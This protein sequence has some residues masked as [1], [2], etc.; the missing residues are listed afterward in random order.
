MSPTS[1]LSII[2]GIRQFGLAGDGAD[3]R[4]LIAAYE[5]QEAEITHL[6]GE[7]AKAGEHDVSLTMH[8]DGKFLDED[9]GEWEL[10][11]ATYRERTK[12]CGCDDCRH[13][14]A[15]N[16]FISQTKENSDTS[17][18]IEPFDDYYLADGP[19]FYNRPDKENSDG[20]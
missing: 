10:T 4:D 16:A 13:Y 20:E 11:E 14:H 1:F 12:D 15:V 7:L 3:L 18:S 9:G 5:R 17:P 19:A 8:A 2:A 6:K